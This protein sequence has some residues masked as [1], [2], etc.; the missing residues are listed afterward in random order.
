ML[1]TSSR[2]DRRGFVARVA[3]VG[4]P[5]AA[6]RAATPHEAGGA[7]LLCAPELVTAGSPPTPAADAY[8]FG[9]LLYIM[10]AGELP[11]RSRNLG[12]SH[13]RPE[14]LHVTSRQLLRHHVGHA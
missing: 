6:R 3:D 4:S 5:S 12:K 2:A 7:M 1:L 10:A 11:Y 14:A 8:S 9:M 13:V